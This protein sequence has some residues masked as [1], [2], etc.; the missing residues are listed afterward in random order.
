MIVNKQK[1]QK[2]YTSL[3][4]DSSS[5][6]IDFVNNLFY[7][8]NC[9]NSGQNELFLDE[10]DYELLI[11]LVEYYKTGGCLACNIPTLFEII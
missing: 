7:G 4:L 10:Q 11:D 8:I 5:K 9:H 3:Y 1:I 2:L 6:S